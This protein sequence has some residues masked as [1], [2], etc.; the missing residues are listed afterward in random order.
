MDEE[1]LDSILLVASQQYE[2]EV[3]EQVLLMASQQY[4][5]EVSSQSELAA[6]VDTPSKPATSRFG[7]SIDL[8]EMIKDAI[9]TKTRQQT[10]WCTD[11]WDAWHSHRTTV[12]TTPQEIPSKLLDMDN[13]QLDYWLSRFLTEVRRQDGHEYYG[14]S[15][16][17]LL[18]GLQRH[19]RLVKP[20]CSIDFLS[21]G[22]FHRVRCVLDA[23]MKLLKKSGVGVSKKQAEIITYEEE[24][25]LWR[26]GLLGEGS[27]K[28]LLNTMVWMCGLFFALRSGAEHCSLTWDQIECR[29]DVLI[30]KQGYAKNRQ[31]GIA[32]RHDAEKVVHHYKNENDPSRC[33]FIYIRNILHFVPRMPL[34]F[35]LL[36]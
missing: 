23:K 31:G 14:D 18:C 3:E 26:K 24:D 1:A 2:E 25:V 7:P 29:D 32:Q 10:K 8:D 12:A 20:G 21:G 4:E 13:E 36:L 27:P 22:S 5:E 35:T 19:L 15:L 30:Y 34:L 6:P 11:T 9:P 28:V 17:N 33:L 16:Y